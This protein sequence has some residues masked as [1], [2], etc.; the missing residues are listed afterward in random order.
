MNYLTIDRFYSQADKLRAEF[1][2][3]FADPLH[4][5]AGRFVWDFWNVPGEYTHLRTPAYTYF[6]KKNYEAFHRYL[7]R[8]GRERL[9][10]HDISPP[11]LS[12]YITGCRQQAHQDKPHGPLAFVYSLTP[13]KRKFRGGETFITKPRA[14]IAP[15]FNR[16][17]LFNPSLTHGVREVKGTMDPREGRLVIHGWFVNPRP[18]WIGPLSVEQVRHT[19]DQAFAI[20]PFEILGPGFGSF[21]LSVGTDG[22]V[23]NSKLLFETFKHSARM[24]ALRPYW[25][26]LNFGKLRSPA[27]LTL[28]LRID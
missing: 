18:F 25:K 12:C 7:V 1:D 27:T 24:K 19:L 2:A 8:F 26:Q 23:K 14:L 5:H 9:G 28:P 22:K 17:T 20:M 10:C 4:G 21:R 6:S 13:R 16:L 11:W 15:E 3:K